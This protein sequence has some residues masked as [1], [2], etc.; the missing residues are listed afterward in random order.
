[1]VML[2]TL[3]PMFYLNQ[4]DSVVKVMASSH[5]KKYG[6]QIRWLPLFCSSNQVASTMAHYLVVARINYLLLDRSLKPES[7]V[8]KK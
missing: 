3:R 6:D 2:T 1:M 4:S 7:G 8:S 5:S